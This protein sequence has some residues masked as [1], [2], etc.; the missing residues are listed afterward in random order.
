MRVA[1]GADHAGVALKRDVRKLLEEM[2][3]EYVDF[4]TDTDAPV[5][6]PDFADRVA[7]EVVAGQFDAGILICGTGIGMAMAAN[8]IRGVRA[9]SA[10]DVET[11]RLAREHND[12]N[13]L[14]LG[15]RTTS[16]DRAMA[17][18]K[19]FLSTGFAGGR[20]ARRIG[21]IAAMEQ[22]S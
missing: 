21:K 5:D 12:A 11:A 20:H 10:G 16:I 13:I 19:V 18:V 17:V 4:G 7:R 14:A 2:H 8:K 1:L 22:P 6:Y 3:V 9:A 15:A